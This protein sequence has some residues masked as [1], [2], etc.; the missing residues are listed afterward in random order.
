MGLLHLNPHGISENPD[1]DNSYKSMLAKIVYVLY[2]GKLFKETLP[3]FR[4]YRGEAKPS[5][6]SSLS[7]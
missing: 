3:L 2:F 1:V 5:Y 6:L 7:R 4:G